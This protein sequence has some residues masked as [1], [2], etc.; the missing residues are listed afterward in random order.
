MEPDD[1]PTSYSDYNGGKRLGGAQQP[2][3]R[4]SGDIG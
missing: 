4:V 1:I 3:L 2:E